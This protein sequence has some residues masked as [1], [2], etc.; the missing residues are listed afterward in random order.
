MPPKRAPDSKDTKECMLQIGKYNN[1]VAWNLEMRASIGAMYGDSALFLTTDV[2]Y[3]PPLP[4]EEDYV[5][6]YPAGP[7][8]LPAIPM[9]AA[10]V[11]DLKKDAF[12]G[13]QREV[14]QQKLDEKKIWNIMWM[15][16]SPASQSKVKEEDGY[17]QANIRN[18][19]VLLWDMIRRTHLTHIFGAQDPMVRL[20]KREQLARYSVLRQGDREFIAS[21]KT[22]YDAQI[23]ANIGAGIAVIDEETMAMDFLH[24]LDYKRYEKMLVHMRRNA[25]CNDPEAYP[26]TLAS[27]L[28]IASGWVD[29]G[30]SS[31]KGPASGSDTHSAFVTADLNLVTKSKDTAAKKQSNAATTDAV[32]AKKKPLSDIQ[33]FVCGGFGHYARDCKSKKSIGKALVAETDEDDYDNGEEEIVYVT[34]CELVLFSRDDVLLDSQAS[35]NVFCNQQLLK[36]IRKSDRQVLLNG[37]QSG[38]KGVRITQEGDFG[39]VG[40]VYYS[41]QSTANIL[42]YAVMI[43]QGNK[44]KYDQRNDRF[45]MRPAGSK[46]VY[47][48]CRKNIPGSEGRFY[49]CDVNTMVKGFAT[50]Y[51]LPIDLPGPEHALIETEFENKLKYT[52]CEVEGAC[53][54]REMLA[55][56]GFPPV[57]KAIEIATSGINFTVTATDFRIAEDIWGP[58]I[59]SLKG[60]T[61]KR[62]T[63]AADTEIGKQLVQQEQILAVDIMYVEGIPSLIGLASPLDLTMAVSLLAFDSIYGSRSAGVVKEGILGFISTLA[64]RNF[65]T[66]LIMSDGEG[67]IGKI[68]DD[69]NMLGIEVDVS[70]A[71]GHVARI[72]RKIQTVKE[73]VRAHTAHQLPFTLTTLGL[74]MLVLFCVSRLNYQT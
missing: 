13:R 57:S 43:D 5:L 47:S 12:T 37:V 49:C 67:A 62:V 2:R 72:E 36:N 24:K 16:M 74:A 41:D 23:Q 64:S 48:F 25:L 10:L 56:M 26:A 50:T 44:V 59:A 61:K 15:R 4:R 66:R 58:D 73:R 1:V 30:S 46:K 7:D 31:V 39:E 55:K 6:V 22:R 42:S 28:R 34:S 8:D 40:K 53:K 52:K 20:N 17:E 33:C 29:E 38:A 68:R 18:D 54:A 69:L 60:K 65:S 45:E 35:V 11:A 32:V 51:P 71:G 70:G 63:Y 9:S 21:F 3:V 27:A 19:C 14:R